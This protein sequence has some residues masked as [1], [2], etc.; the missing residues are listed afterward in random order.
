[1]YHEVFLHTFEQPLKHYP[2]TFFENCA[3]SKYFFLCTPRNQGCINDHPKP[4]Q[5]TTHYAI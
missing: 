3:Q 4:L 5:N 1:M 2:K